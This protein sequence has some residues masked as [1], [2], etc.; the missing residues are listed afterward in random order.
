[1][2]ALGGAVAEHLDAIDPRLDGPTARALELIGADLDRERRD[3]GSMGKLSYLS[4]G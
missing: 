3:F 1:L 2:E 4:G